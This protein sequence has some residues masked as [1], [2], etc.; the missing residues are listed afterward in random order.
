[1]PLGSSLW[2]QSRGRRTFVFQARCA[3]VRGRKTQSG[4]YG[5]FGLVA[6]LH[7]CGLTVSGFEDLYRPIGICLGFIRQ[8]ACLGRRAAGKS[9]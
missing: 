7:S 2:G 3:A 8:L 5:A 1:M 6:V 9:L 4:F